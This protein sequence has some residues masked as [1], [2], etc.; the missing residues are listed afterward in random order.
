ML[1][2]LIS[3]VLISFCLSFSAHAEGNSPTRITRAQ[4]IDQWKGEAIKQMRE[5]RIPASITLAQGILES[6]DGNSELAREANN[7]FGIKCHGWTGKKVYHDDDRK[8]ECF[9]KYKTAHQSFEDHS[10][11]L[12]RSRYAFLFDYKITDYKSWAKGLKKA[13]YATNPKYPALLIRIIEEN[14]LAQYDREGLKKGRIKTEPSNTASTPK[15]GRQSGEIEIILGSQ[16]SQV[17]ISDNGIKYVITDRDITT[18]DLAESLQLGEWQVVKYNDLS[19]GA[20]IKKGDRVYIQPKKRKSKTHQT[21]TVATGE[22]LR[23]ISQLYGVK[24]KK[25]CK[26]NGLTE[27]SRIMPGDII[28]LR[29]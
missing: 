7:H 8:Q 9:R 27:Q 5:H 15:P 12:K 13:G 21:H 16:N 22:T 14:N 29:K 11:F 18:R 10:H 6:G 19:K 28:K 24:I 17:F 26:Y 20:K 25:L 23:S 1:R 4:Y 2:T 3:F